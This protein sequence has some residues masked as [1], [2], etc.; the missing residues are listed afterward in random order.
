MN[1]GRFLV[2]EI[3]ALFGEIPGDRSVGLNVNL[4]QSR[5][6]FAVGIDGGL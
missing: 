2:F 5:E 3:P 1:N 6:S 4:V